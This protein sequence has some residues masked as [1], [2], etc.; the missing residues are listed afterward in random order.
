MSYRIMLALLAVSCVVVG[1]AQ[2][3]Q[4]GHDAQHTGRSQYNGTTVGVLKWKYVIG[5][6]APGTQAAIVEDTVYATG[7]GIFAINRTTGV[8]IWDLSFPCQSTA[9][10][11]ADGTVYIGSSNS[12]VY[13][14]Q[15]Y[16]LNGSTGVIKW[17]WSNNYA[18]VS[19]PPSVLTT[20]SSLVP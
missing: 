14:P 12:S 13:A 17:T 19:A 2:W 4:R 6:A 8:L 15:F 7:N 18:V 1:G 20:L 9:A 11:G 3:M 5:N 10:I 16:A